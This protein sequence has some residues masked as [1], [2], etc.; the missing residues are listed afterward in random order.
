MNKNVKIN[1]HPQLSDNIIY[2][3]I[4]DLNL[5][6]KTNIDPEQFFDSVTSNFCVAALEEETLKLSFP[7]VATSEYAFVTIEIINKKPSLNT[8]EFNSAFEKEINR[9]SEF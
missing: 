1:R 7:V 2:S 3:A 8:I 4:K 9:T 6:Y 5:K